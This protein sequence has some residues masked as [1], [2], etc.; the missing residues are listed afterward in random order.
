MGEGIIKSLRVVGSGAVSSIGGT[1]LATH[2]AFRAGVSGYQISSHFNKRR[3]LIRYA[4]IPDGALVALSDALLPLEAVHPGHANMV[5]IAA[6][7]LVECLQGFETLGALPVFISCAETLPRQK[8]KLTSGLLKHL[9]IQSRI[10][11]D[12]QNSRVFATGRAGGFQAIETAFRY[13]EVSGAGFALVGGV[14]SY[15][16]YLQQISILDAEDR[17]LVEGA[18]DGFVPGE[19]GSF[20]LLATAD[21]VQKYKLHSFLTIAQPFNAAEEGHRYSESPYR[22]DGLANAFRGALANAPEIAIN[23]IYSSFNG[24]RFGSKEFGVA[25][26]RNGSRI[27]PAAK[28]NHPA[29]C[30]GDIGAAFGPMLVSLMSREKK[31]SGLAYCSS[32]GAYRSA[33]CAWK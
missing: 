20:L 18:S 13:L 12:L 33:L 8:P 28:I 26:I 23:Q 31:C 30:F 1:A 15:R 7:A 14:D 4:N 29:D 9:S 5:R 27:S 17:L 16:Y 32:D 6:S 10:P 3:K 25:M 19:A 21:A 24:E 11:L 2:A 22:G